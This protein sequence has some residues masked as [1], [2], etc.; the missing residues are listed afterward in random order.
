MKLPDP[1]QALAP[2][3][4]RPP[5]KPPCALCDRALGNVLGFKARWFCW[6]CFAE[7]QR[8]SAYKAYDRFHGDDAANFEAWFQAKK[9]EAA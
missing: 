8:D 9:R 5:S 6:R 4:D 2:S 1:K 7:W 3:E